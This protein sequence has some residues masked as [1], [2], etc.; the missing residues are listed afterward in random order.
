MVPLSEVLSESYIYLE[1]MKCK[2]SWST[3]EAT[4]VGI[5]ANKETVRRKEVVIHEDRIC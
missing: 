4:T 5:V 1:V 2:I 3:D